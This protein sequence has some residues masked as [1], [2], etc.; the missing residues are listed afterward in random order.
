[1]RRQLSALLESLSGLLLLSG[2]M[3]GA[4]ALAILAVRPGLLLCGLA[5]WAGATFFSALIGFAIPLAGPAGLN[6]LLVGLSI[7]YLVEPALA[8]SVSLSFPVL[9]QPSSALR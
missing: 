3:P 1:M 6:P 4:I 7:G 8:R 9:R 5:A 2:R